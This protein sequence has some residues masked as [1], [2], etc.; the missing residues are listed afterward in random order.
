MGR[1][2][3]R[4]KNPV[5]LSVKRNFKKVGKM[6]NN[7]SLA[8]SLLQKYERLWTTT[9]GE[10]YRNTDS[11]AARELGNRTSTRNRWNKLEMHRTKRE[12]SAASAAALSIRQVEVASSRWLNYRWWIRKRSEE[13][14]KK[15]WWKTKENGVREK[16]QES[17]YIFD[18][19][20][21]WFLHFPQETKHVRTITSLCVVLVL[22]IKMS[23]SL[24][25]LF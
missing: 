3:R 20:S 1:N 25:V 19:I 21:H 16:E 10:R 23:L 4:K 8:L 18:G 12:K 22:F 11:K 13:N 6:R 2:K 9:L 15:Q 17:F 14:R 7:G 24:S 5:S